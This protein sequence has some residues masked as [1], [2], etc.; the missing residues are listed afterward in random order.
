MPER[1][2]LLVLGNSTGGI[3]TH[4]A[5]LAKACVVAGYHVTVC[6]PASTVSLFDFSAAG[7]DVVVLPVGLGLLLRSHRRLTALLAAH[8]VV[9]AHGL[10]AGVAV[11]LASRRQR[12]L[13][14]TWHNAPLSQ[15]ARLAA[16]VLLE[17]IAASR[18]DVTIGASEDLVARARRAGASDARFV[19]VAPPLLSTPSAPPD[20]LR[21]RLGLG[22]R[23]VV[24]SVG[25]LHRQKRLDVLVAA[26]ECWSDAEAGPV[27]LIAG[28]GPERDS[29]QR[30]IA[31]RGVDVRLLGR[32]TDIADLLSIA[33]VVVL[34]SSWEARPLVAQ[35][36]LAAGRALVTTGVGGIPA[37]VGSA[38]VL[39]PVGDPDALASAVTRLLADA[40]MRHQLER[41]AIVQAGRWPDAD[42]VARQ[43]MTVYAE[44]GGHA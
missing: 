19:P 36:A 27:V 21:H 35:E 23:P 8:T 15:G 22:E 4:V 12:R 20:M 39:V 41:E 16:H 40:D 25:R 1:S 5:S 2:V 37:L 7:A 34:P 44:L 24:L 38:A 30:T 3:G 18:A 13:V 29:L 31:A 42:D 14:T 32:R 10:Q 6:A 11:G 17:R 9:H 33:D 43:L 28:D 26:A